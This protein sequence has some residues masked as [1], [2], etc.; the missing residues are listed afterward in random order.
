M[1]QERWPPWKA[2][3]YF[4]EVTSPQ[5]CSFPDR[6]T[7]IWQYSPLRTEP[8]KSYLVYPRIPWWYLGQQYINRK[9]SFLLLFL[10]YYVFPHPLRPFSERHWNARGAA[11]ENATTAWEGAAVSP[12]TA[13]G[14]GSPSCRVCSSED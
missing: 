4:L 3:L 1:L 14:S 12:L 8:L 9:E 13:K 5:G 7:C 11:L 6:W 2:G 10:H